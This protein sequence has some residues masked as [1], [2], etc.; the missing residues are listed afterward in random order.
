[1]ATS[2]GS[3]SIPAVA[4]VVDLVGTLDTLV[5]RRPP[6]DPALPL[7]VFVGD[8]ANGLVVGFR[9][10]L[11]SSQGQ[12]TVP[13]VLI[14][15]PGQR[16]P[17]DDVELLEHI[18]N[19]ITR[20]A[21]PG[22]GRIDL[23][24]FRTVRDILDVQCTQKW[25]RDRP[26][27]LRDKLYA[28]RRQAGP[29]VEWLD[30]LVSSTSPN[31]VV[32][33]G[34]ALLRPA[35]VDLPRLLYGRRLARGRRMRWFSEQIARVT[36][37]SDDDVL[38]AALC[39]TRNGDERHNALLV[40]RVLLL[41][42]VRDLDTAF[43][44][45]SLLSWRRRQRVTPFVLLLCRVATDD[46]AHRLLDT[47]GGIL[48]EDPSGTVLAA[49]ALRGDVPAS[50][51]VASGGRRLAPDDASAA[52]TPLLRGSP[53]DDRVLV[54]DVPA[55]PADE[56]TAAWLAVNQKVQPATA[57][58][59]LLA[60]VATSVVAA[61]VV[62]G[63]LAGAWG[64]VRDR[65][66]GSSCPGVDLIEGEWIGVGDGTADCTFVPAAVADNELE[67]GMREV[68][69][70][71][72]A[73]NAEL[74]AG[75]DPYSTVVFFAPLTLPDEPARVGQTS[76]RQ[77]RGV[78]L[79]QA[80]ANKQQAAGDPNKRLVRVL[81]ANPGDRFVH[82]E[83]VA[84]QIVAAAER[85]PTIVGVVGI[86]QSRTSSRRA[87]GILAE[88]HLPV[89]AGPVTGDEMVTASEYY[90]QVSPLNRRVAEVLVSFAG[91]EPI[92]GPGPEPIRPMRNAVVVLDHTDEYSLNL[93]DDLLQSLF[94]TG[95]S[96][97]RAF[98]YPF[99]GRAADE[100][101]PPALPGWAEQKDTPDELA[102]A[103]CGAMDIDSD[104]V[105]FTG[106]APQL[107]G[108]LDSMIG[109]PACNG[110]VTIVGGT[111]ITKFV[112]NP[113]IDLGRYG[114][115][116]IYYGAFA[117]P[118]LRISNR[119]DVFFRAY[120]DTY[121]DDG[122]RVDMSDPALTFDALLTMQTA[123]NVVARDQVEATP[124]TVAGTLAHGQVDFDGATGHIAV[125][126]D[127]E[128]RVPINKPVLVLDAHQASE[129]PLLACGLMAG[130]VA[131]TT[132]GDGQIACP[133]DEAP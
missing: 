51:Q 111:D 77:L 62:V 106:R 41:A 84:E 52:L 26:K 39:L 125:R 18:A 69:E 65:T 35:A 85:D 120:L 66:G 113:E 91:N 126:G 70:R 21:P 23:P 122:I 57:R 103:V 7:L 33:F 92:V 31:R 127:D 74:V 15:G 61:G 88:H 93:A 68:E 42:L 56:R 107:K 2:A 101:E 14:G 124:D 5:E 8:G 28:R 95:H 99:A 100:E 117:S 80:E 123:I 6:R 76:L 96:D 71:I 104:V 87:I 63:L 67:Q 128:N 108:M 79:A 58:F 9:D 50:L 59:P 17:T 1:M 10:R 53:V 110:R 132:W 133:D 118:Q 73:E 131:Y 25:Y 16:A 43:H 86:G 90:Y 119:A 20:A 13:H 81:L 11:H 114:R 121:G 115:M 19:E 78:Q 98:S 75:D 3:A 83:A 109:P 112:G 32:R 44:S 60:P 46:A 48:D 55:D 38:T 47:W 49:A 27:E 24:G 105:F 40:R 34:Q 22:T 30:N 37:R 64:L 12:T 89:V 97:V 45:S 94:A 130:S 82:G 72:A 4:G 129:A 54:V 36:G 102:A 29:L 116:R